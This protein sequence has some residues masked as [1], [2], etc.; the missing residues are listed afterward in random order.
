M[1]KSDNLDNWICVK[2]NGKTAFVSKDYAKVIYTVKVG[3]AE[4]K[5]TSA[6]SKKVVA[7]A[8]K[9][10]GNRYVY[11]GSSLK[12]GTDCSGF[13]MK[14]YQHFGYRLARSSAAQARNGRKVKRSKLQPGD[15]LFYKK[16]GRISH[17]SMYIGSGKVIHASNE[18]NGIIIS[19]VRY[20]KAC[21]CV[22]ILK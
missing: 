13:T 8:K 21:R 18:K 19:S 16:K 6:L 17:V 4:N 15:L 7:Y 12:H 1:L 11:G 3:S 20:R 22:R 5:K 14:V 10:L 9:F 2:Y